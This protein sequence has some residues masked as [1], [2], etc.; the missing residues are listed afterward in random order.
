MKLLVFIFISFTFMYVA[1][2]DSSSFDSLISKYIKIK[3]ALII[4]DE[5]LVN[6]EAKEFVL[7]ITSKPFEISSLEKATLNTKIDKIT[8][9]A[10]SVGENDNIESSRTEFNQFSSL[11]WDLVSL[12]NAKLKDIY[13]FYCP[14]KKAYWISTENK[15][16][17]PYYGKKMLSC[18]SLK[19]KKVQ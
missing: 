16:Q 4:G 2:G 7:L 14:M 11:V 10:R 12:S 13:Y 1:K 6:K 8:K 19:D 18:G 9:A 17:N 3:D 5:S 15:V